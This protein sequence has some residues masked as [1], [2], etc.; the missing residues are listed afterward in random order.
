[1]YE[2]D[3]VQSDRSRLA[4]VLDG[5]GLATGSDFLHALL[6]ETVRQT[7]L[8]IFSWVRQGEKTFT[9]LSAG[10]VLPVGGGRGGC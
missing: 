4:A 6:R 8:G 1:M 10:D 9:A 3:K 2:K 5:D 7:E